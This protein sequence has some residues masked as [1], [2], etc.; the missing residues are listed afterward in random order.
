MYRPLCSLKFQIVFLF[1]RRA[2]LSSLFPLCPIDAQ[3][4]ELD[5][6]KKAGC[7]E[8]KQG[9][10][11]CLLPVENSGNCESTFG[12]PH[13]KGGI[14][15]SYSLFLIFASIISKIKHC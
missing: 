13:G 4:I 2:Y 9:R 6:E 12:K 3:G 15:V 10:E 7:F 1:G 5:I 14:V 8:K 11:V